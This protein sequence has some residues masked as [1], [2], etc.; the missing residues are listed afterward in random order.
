MRKP[1]TPLRR[2][3][4][5]FT[6]VEVLVASGLLVLMASGIYASITIASRMVYD[7]R[8]RLE[9]QGLAC[10]RCW[11]AYRDTYD[12]NLSYP[13]VTTTAVPM[14]HSLFPFG[15]TVRRGI[16]VYTDHVTIEV[17]VDWTENGRAFTEGFSVDRYD[18][19]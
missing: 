15:G 2:W 16:T 6:L 17:R 8:Q 3:R 19:R 9:A 7:A 18:D 11:I 5:F 4:R 14:G 13:A 12:N 1:E 10:D